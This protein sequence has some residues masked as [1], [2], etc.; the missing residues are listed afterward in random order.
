M[1]LEKTLFRVHDRLLFQP[2]ARACSLILMATGFPL[3]TI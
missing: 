2:N 3:G 1:E